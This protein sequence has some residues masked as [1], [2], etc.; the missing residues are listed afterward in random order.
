MTA[1]DHEVATLE[2]TEPI[3]EVVTYPLSEVVARTGVPSERWIRIRLNAGKIR[4]R[5]AGRTW[6]MTAD[7]IAG[8]IAYLAS[9][10][11][12]SP[13]PASTLPTA[14]PDTT[15]LS[16]ASRRRLKRRRTH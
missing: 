4:G 12:Y 14:S 16:A 8:L 15:G 9:G 2:V 6:R 13:S 7:D 5:R 10:P 1:T 3:G 11:E